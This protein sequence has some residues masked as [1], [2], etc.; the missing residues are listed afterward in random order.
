MAEVLFELSLK[1][2][3]QTETEKYMSSREINVRKGF[4]CEALW[5][6]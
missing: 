4:T 6:A 3:V 2:K 1:D 5:R